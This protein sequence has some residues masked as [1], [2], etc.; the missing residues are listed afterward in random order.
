[1][2]VT[3]LN[4]QIQNKNSRVCVGLDPRLEWLPQKILRRNKKKY[5]VSF[6][7]AATAILEFNKEVIDVITPFAAAIKPQLA[8]YE[9]YGPEG[10]KVFAQT[11]EYAKSLDLLT[12]ADA[13]RGDI[14]S[15]AQAYANAFLGQTELFGQKKP[16]YDVD[17]ITVNP[18][19][20]E[21]SLEPFVDTCHQYGKGIFILVKT[22][23]SGSKDLQDLVIDG[24]NISRRLAQMVT[25]KACQQLDDQGY[26]DIG[27]V[28][29]ATFPKEALV[30]RQLMPHSV[31]LVPGLGSQGGK[32]TDV[33]HFFNP[34]GLGAI[35]NSSRG[36]TFSKVGKEGANY[37]S[38]IKTAVQDLQKSI[39]QV[40]KK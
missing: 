22:S 17:C 31:F 35:V 3:R 37:L 10:L 11:V 15:T 25:R 20:G 12:I 28:V 19:L 38:C 39:N 24:L 18:F 32:V 1:V 6:L 26:S 14:E 5:G 4:Q 9:Q 30:L 8:F 16:C 36:I 21:D 27:A 2:F 13:K 7:A 23:N 34:D 40:L 33:A 29:G